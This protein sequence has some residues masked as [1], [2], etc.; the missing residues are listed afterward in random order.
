[1]RVVVETVEPS[2]GC[3]GC[4]V[5]SS[6]GEG[7]AVVGRSR[8]LPV[9]GRQIALWWRKRRLVCAEPLCGKGSFVERVEAVGPRGG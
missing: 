8:T 9:S 6:A 5:I 7:S 2:A 3:P 4:G 1:M